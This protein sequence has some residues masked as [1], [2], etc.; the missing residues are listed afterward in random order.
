MARVLVC[1]ALLPTTRS[2]MAITAELAKKCREMTDK[3]FPLR[4]P[5]K[6]GREHGT[7]K[8]V[9]DYFG[10]CVLNGGNM[11]E[12]PPEPGS[13]TKVPKKK[14]SETDQLLPKMRTFPDG[15]I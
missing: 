4:A 7:A 5:G 8:E 14:G 10:K 6:P 3:V 1:L 2:A 15:L 9:R 11:G 13:F 12:Q